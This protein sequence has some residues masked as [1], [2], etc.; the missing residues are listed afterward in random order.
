VPFYLHPARSIEIARGLTEPDPQLGR[1]VSFMC[2]ATL[3]YTEDDED[4]D[5]EE[6]EDRYA[7]RTTVDSRWCNGALIVMAKEG[8]LHDNEMARIAMV[9][10]IFREDQLDLTAPVPDSLAAWIAFQ[11]SLD[12]GS[13]SRTPPDDE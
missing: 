3:D 5:D 7:P 12:R 6:D 1:R 10:G 13:S 11:H 2:H 4:A 8:V 9:L